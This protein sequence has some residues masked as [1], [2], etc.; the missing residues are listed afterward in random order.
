MQ[1]YKEFKKPK[2]SYICHK[3]LLLSSICN[4]FGSE[5]KQIFMEEEL[6]KILKII[7]LITNLEEYQKIYKHVWR[8]HKS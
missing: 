5:K 1:K 6:F 4:K 2:I 8:K 3:T 7:G